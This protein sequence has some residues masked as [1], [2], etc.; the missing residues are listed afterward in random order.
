MTRNQIVNEAMKWE[1]TPWR[2]QGRNQRGVDCAGLIIRVGNDLEI[3]KYDIRNYP[4]H[5]HRDAFIRHFQAVLKEKTVP[6]RLKGDVVLLRDGIYACHCGIID[7]AQDGT[8]F[9]IH[10]YQPRGKVVRE[11]VTK[12]ILSKMTH[13]FSFPEVE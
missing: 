5:T 2:H 13:C 12:E 9:I 4:R 8:E 11:E 7:Y 3:I 6:Q 1:N 10:A